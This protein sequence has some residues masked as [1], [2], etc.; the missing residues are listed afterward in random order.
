V[1][2][3]QWQQWSKWILV[4][5]SK[6]IMKQQI[7]NENNSSWNNNSKEVNATSCK[8]GST[9]GGKDRKLWVTITKKVHGKSKEETLKAKKWETTLHHSNSNGGKRQM[10]IG[11]QHLENKGLKMRLIHI[12][13]YI[14][15]GA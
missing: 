13:L 4:D 12:K 14:C 15:V 10:K 1:Q 3:A 2:R 8:K 11:Q 9:K 5:G 7:T 6:V